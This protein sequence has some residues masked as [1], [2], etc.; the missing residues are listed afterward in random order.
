M[1][2]AAMAAADPELASR[3]AQIAWPAAQLEL[4]AR[5][6]AGIGLLL[7]RQECRELEAL[8][9]EPL[10]RSTVV[11]QQHGYGRGEY[12]YFADP[13]PPLVEGLRRELYPHLVP[14][15]NDWEQRLKTGRHFPASLGELRA[16][17]RELGQQRPTPLLLRY[18]PDDYNCLHQDLYGELVFPLQLCVLLSEPGTEFEGG[19]FLMTEQRPRMQSRGEVVPLQQ[20]GAV[21]FATR[22]RPVQGTRSSYRTNLKHGVSRIR[23]GKRLTLGI[24]FHDAT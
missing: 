23:S 20:G 15:A 3:V 1:S 18:G 12:R 24:I 16:Q 11:M 8:Y 19:E 22:H 14:I 2:T 17:C 5:G 13:L 6:F 9:S 4:D 10:F 7:S 21:V